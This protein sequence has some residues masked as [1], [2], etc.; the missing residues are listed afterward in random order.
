MY[1]CRLSTFESVLTNIE[2]V[3]FKMIILNILI[4]V[5][6]F[7]I[8]LLFLKGINIYSLEISEM[9]LGVKMVNGLLGLILK[10]LDTKQARI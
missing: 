9:F 5:R 7:F 6:I 1:C 8:R 4:D 2:I 10:T 3:G